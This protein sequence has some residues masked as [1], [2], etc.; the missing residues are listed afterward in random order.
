MGEW[1]VIGYDGSTFE[2]SFIN[3]SKA[4]FSGLMKTYTTLNYSVI[5]FVNN[6]W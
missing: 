4:L 6:S 1:T 5:W 2:I 3:I